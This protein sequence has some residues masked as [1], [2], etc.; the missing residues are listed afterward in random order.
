MNSEVAPLRSR[1]G[2]WLLA[3]GFLTVAAARAAES[4]V[5]A[6]DCPASDVLDAQCLTLQSV[7]TPPENAVT[8]LRSS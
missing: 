2:V 1:G 4:R 6:S 3:L 8:Q 5:A 7:A